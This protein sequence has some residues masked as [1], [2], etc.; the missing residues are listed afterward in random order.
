MLLLCVNAKIVS[1]VICPVASIQ[2]KEEIEKDKSEKIETSDE[3]N[4]E[5]EDIVKPVDFILTHISKISFLQESKISYLNNNPNLLTA[6]SKVLQQPPKKS[7]F[8]TN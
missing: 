2:S 5:N 4:N 1:S 6:Y 7:F 8:S 3:E